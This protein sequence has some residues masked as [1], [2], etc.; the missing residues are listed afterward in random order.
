MNTGRI[1]DS[2]GV[3]ESRVIE[4]L[5]GATAI[6]PRIRP[7]W[8]TIPTFSIC[9]HPRTSR[10]IVMVDGDPYG[11]QCKACGYFGHVSKGWPPHTRR[12]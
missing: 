7:W 2:V 11:H 6:Q 3:E 5:A 12:R 10:H 4:K 9:Y 8:E 1:L